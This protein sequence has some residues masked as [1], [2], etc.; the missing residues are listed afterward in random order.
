MFVEVG[1]VAGAREALVAVRFGKFIVRD[2]DDL[3]AKTAMQVNSSRQRIFLT[4]FPP[5]PSRSHDPGCLYE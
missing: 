3:F 2:L 1:I 4:D 5:Q